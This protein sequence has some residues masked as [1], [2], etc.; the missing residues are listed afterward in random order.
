VP[1]DPKEAPGERGV[2]S[3]FGVTGD[4]VRAMLGALDLEEGL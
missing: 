1:E 2:K 4:V 3:P